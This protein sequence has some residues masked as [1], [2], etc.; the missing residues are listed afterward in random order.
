MESG[1]GLRELLS[2]GRVS[3]FLLARP[4]LAL[5]NTTSHVAALDGET[6]EP[7]SAQCL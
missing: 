7:L 4:V 2:I 3:I 1:R 6:R 5:F